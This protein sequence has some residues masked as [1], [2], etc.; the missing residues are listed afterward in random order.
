[1]TDFLDV[2]VRKSRRALRSA[3]LDLRDGDTDGAVNRSYYAMVNA[4]RAVLMKAGVAEDQLPRTHAGLIAAFGQWAVKTGKVDPEMGRALN[5][6]ETLRLQSDYTGVEATISAAEGTV[7][8]AESFVHAV[9]HAF[10]LDGLSVPAELHAQ[11]FPDKHLPQRK[12]DARSLGGLGDVESKRRQAV[13]DWLQYR[14]NRASQS[15]D[16]TDDHTPDQGQ[17][18]AERPP[19]RDRGH[20]P[21]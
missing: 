11:A 16:A 1:M 12:E 3:R 2:L 4:A 17:D 14:K 7:A 6:T 18:S 15:K 8:R 9:G 13:Q 10:D 21:D 20:D 5:V 19:T